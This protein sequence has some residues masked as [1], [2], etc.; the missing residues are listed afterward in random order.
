MSATSRPWRNGTAASVAAHAGPGA[1]V[2]VA[3]DAKRLPLLDQ[4]L[5]MQDALPEAGA[6]AAM[7]A[8]TNIKEANV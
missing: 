2:A 8:F 6:F 5:A 7:R 3:A 1:E 4:V